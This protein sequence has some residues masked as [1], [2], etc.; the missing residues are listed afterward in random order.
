MIGSQTDLSELDK[1]QYLKSALTGEAAN[2]IRIFEN[3]EINYTKAWAILDRAYE[4]K[5]ILVSRHLTAV[6]N[7]PV[8]AT[9]STSGLTKLADD[10]QQHVAS[11]KSLGV[12]VGSEVIVA[13]LESRLP[14]STAERWEEKLD[15]NEYPTADE[16]YEFLY[17]SA[18]FAS[19]TKR[20]KSIESE[21]S[22]PPAKRKRMSYASNQA[23]VLNTSRNC[24]VCKI[25]RHPLYLCEKFKQLSVQK[26]I[27][28]VRGAKLCYNCMRSHK[29]SVCKFSSCTICQRR[30]NT[31]L[32]L[33]N[34][35]NARGSD[36][37]N[38]TPTKSD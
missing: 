14:K 22:E 34:Y 8:L 30:H 31:L 2:K 17:K 27:D 23:L 24:T 4:V 7:P 10:M 12:S 19:K 37:S 32:H 21:R 15:R 9:E 38:S 3:D 5:R 35:S 20:V 6:L 33:D 16:M 13:T 11:L 28:A 25:K 29:G 26:R 36:A 1:L 18:V